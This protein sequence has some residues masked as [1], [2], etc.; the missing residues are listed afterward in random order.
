MNIINIINYDNKLFISLRW[1]QVLHLIIN[2]LVN[3]CF[4]NFSFCNNRCTSG[5]YRLIIFLQSYIR[6]KLICIISENNMSITY[7]TVVVH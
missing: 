5:H 2:K 4:N 6:Q 7:F 3:F 1:R